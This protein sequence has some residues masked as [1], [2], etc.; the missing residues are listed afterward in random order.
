[1]VSLNRRFNVIFLLVVALPLVLVYLLQ[2][3]VYMDAL[4]ETVS[5]QTQ[6]LLEQIAQNVEKEL[7]NAS[8]LAAVLM[9]DQDLNDWADQWAL[10]P[11][12]PQRVAAGWK[13]SQRLQSIFNISNRVGAIALY[14][15]DGT[16]MT[17]SNYPNIRSFA[18]ADKTA[19][20]EAKAQPNR[21]VIADSLSGIT[22]NGGDQFILSAIICPQGN[23]SGKAIDAILVM[24]RVPY[25]DQF[26]TFPSRENEA[27]L[28]IVGRDG[29]SLLSAMTKRIVR[30]DWETIQNLPPGNSELSILGRPFLVN[31]RT[32]EM[33]HWTFLLA[34]DK[35]SISTRILTYQRYLYP[36]L[37]LMLSLFLMY[38]MVFV[39]RVTKPIGTVMTNMRRFA[40]GLE[41]LPARRETIR[42]L[43]ALNENFDHMVT[44]IRRLNV[45]RQQQSE[46]RLKA[47]IQALQFQISPH[48]V[49]NTL[50]SIRMMALA[51]RN[52]GIRDMT[53]ALIRILADSYASAEPLTSLA[54]EIANLKSYLLIMKVRFGEHFH[55]SYDLDPETMEAS[56]LRMSLQPLVENAILHG[57]ADL[58]R[59]GRLTLRSRRSGDTWLL[60][61]VDNGVGMEEPVRLGLLAALPNQTDD[62]A[63]G[64]VSFHRIGLRNVHERIRLNFGEPFGLTIESTQGSG[65]TVRILLPFKKRG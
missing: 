28:I 31:T 55:V 26:T 11:A 59:Q 49:A 13:M 34:M 14:M 65:T 29:S 27:S 22:D 7:N 45:E 57:F 25:L 8:V 2:S 24:F 35:A 36:A 60:E 58:S 47:E 46:R 41:P 64:I 6:G 4:V 53:Q 32:L 23:E 38:S 37:A 3:R 20:R 15:R 52:D 33:A 50:N 63:A 42:E 12:G 62:P 56:I 16:V 40:A 51:A 17:S 30:K 9:Y 39:S 44:E 61:V 19:Y 43:A 48:F 18:L 5:A 21:V 54:D 10:S 1:M